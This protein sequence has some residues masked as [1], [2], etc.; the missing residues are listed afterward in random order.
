RLLAGTVKEP[1]DGR[2]LFREPDLS[3]KNKVYKWSGVLKELEKANEQVKIYFLTT[4]PK[5]NDS[6][7]NDFIKNTLID[8]RTNKIEVAIVTEAEAEKFAAK[9]RK[10]MEASNIL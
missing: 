4:T 6:E 2:F 3:I 7:L 10:D 1:Q 9:V 5:V 8:T